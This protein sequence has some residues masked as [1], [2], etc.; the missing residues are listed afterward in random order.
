[1]LTE[2]YFL[3]APLEKALQPI[4]KLFVLKIKNQNQTY[5]TTMSSSKADS[6]SIS[7]GTQV[8]MVKQVKLCFECLKFACNRLQQVGS[9]Q[10]VGSREVVGREV[11]STLL[12]G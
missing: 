3:F 8:L 9:S 6:G 11:N 1:M 12:H 10:V 2:S 4:M 5:G 7:V